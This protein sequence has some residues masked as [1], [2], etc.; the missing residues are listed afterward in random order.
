MNWIYRCMC[1]LKKNENFNKSPLFGTL[2]GHINY[3]RCD[4][5]VSIIATCILQLYVHLVLGL[6]DLNVLGA[7]VDENIFLHH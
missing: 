2:E 1:Q 3:D 5:C 4:E 6:I 7:P